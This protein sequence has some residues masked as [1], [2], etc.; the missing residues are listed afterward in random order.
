MTS[1]SDRTEKA[2]PKRLRDSKRKGQL[3]KSQEVSVAF[4]LLL[5]V[6]TARL[7]MPLSGGVV[8]EEFGGMLQSAGNAN[9]TGGTGSSALRMMVA[10]VL[11]V[12][13]MAV[14]AALAAGFA[15]VGFAFA[16]LAAKPKLSH[17]SIKK[18]LQRFKPSKAAWELVR[19]TLKI[20]LLVLLAWGPLT[21]ITSEVASLRGFNGGI[22]SILNAADPVPGCSDDAGHRCRRLRD[23]AL[24]EPQGTPHDQG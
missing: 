14:V 1:R 22:E 19:S 18:G 15:Q 2:T 4:S 23:P 21:S 17:L 9:L 10:T 6:I 11:P 12:L 24:P 8:L 16:P 13:A 20:G 7:I 3:P 5:L